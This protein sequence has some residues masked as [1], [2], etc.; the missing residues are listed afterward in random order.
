MQPQDTNFA[1]CA[2]YDVRPNMCRLFPLGRMGE[3]DPTNGHTTK[4][5]YF[6]QDA[7][8]GRHGPCADDTTW[9]DWVGLAVQ[10]QNEAGLNVYMG[11]AHAARDQIKD[12]GVTDVDGWLDHKARQAI[13][14]AVFYILPTSL[15]PK[16]EL[17]THQTALAICQASADILPQTIRA[18]LE[19]RNPIAETAPAYAEALA[20]HMAVL[21]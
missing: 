4:W 9:G 10:A 15:T 20:A 7:K 2:I 19:G 21:S 14:S 16:R 8:C 11:M 1:I 12:A 6:L 5:R 18:L 17:R 3:I 13:L